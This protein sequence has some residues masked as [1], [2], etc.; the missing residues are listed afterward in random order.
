MIQNSVSEI[1][2]KLESIEGVSSVG[3]APEDKTQ[4]MTFQVKLEDATYLNDALEQRVKDVV[5]QNSTSTDNDV[6]LIVH[7]SKDHIDEM[8]EDE[9]FCFWVWVYGRIASISLNGQKYDVIACN[10]SGIQVRSVPESGDEPVS[11]DS[12]W[13]EWENTDLRKSDFV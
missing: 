8:Y 9:L 2:R 1:R 13:V 6:E 11:A 3:A 5:E 12:R 10:Q 7:S 4:I